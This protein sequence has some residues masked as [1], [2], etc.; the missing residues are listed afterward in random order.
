[1]RVVGVGLEQRQLPGGEFVGVLADVGRGDGEERLVA[2]E[3]IGMVI[4]G[5]VAGGRRG[6]AARPRRDGAV[7]IAGFLAAERREV[8]C[9]GGWRR[10][11]RSRREKAATEAASTRRT[12]EQEEFSF[13]WRE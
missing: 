8:L 3:R 6:D 1:M 9:R 13:S 2:G 4:A 10:R 12:E 11:R 5:L 7:G